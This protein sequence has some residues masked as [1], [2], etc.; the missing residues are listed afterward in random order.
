[1]K[2]MTW[3][4]KL[5]IAAIILALALAGFGIV[6]A[7]SYGSL[8]LAFISWAVGTLCGWYGKNIYDK[9]FKDK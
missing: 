8:L 6:S 7:M 2:T 4:T 3:K 1:M 9:Y 5:I